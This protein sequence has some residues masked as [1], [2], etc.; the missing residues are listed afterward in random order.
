MRNLTGLRFGRLVAVEATQERSHGCVVWSC[1]CDCGK[2]KELR[3]PHLTRQKSPVRS[4]G[5]LRREV[6]AS[7]GHRSGGRRRKIDLQK[8]AEL[9]AQGVSQT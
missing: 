4:C 9:R 3:G 5:C 8:L 2:W 6:A 7:I 1:R